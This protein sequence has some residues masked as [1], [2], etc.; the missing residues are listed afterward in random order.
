MG[1]LFWLGTMVEGRVAPESR[2]SE[3]QQRKANPPAQTNR[4]REGCGSADFSG[5]SPVASALGIRSGATPRGQSI[6]VTAT[7]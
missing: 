5:A 3:E 7:S 6:A 1:L 4:V 2:S